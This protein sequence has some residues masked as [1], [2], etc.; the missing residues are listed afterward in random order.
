MNN[1]LEMLTHQKAVAEK[2]LAAAK[3][4]EKQLEPELKLLTRRENLLALYPF[5]YV[6]IFLM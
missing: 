5:R 6:R 2:K 3:H 1:K 4:K